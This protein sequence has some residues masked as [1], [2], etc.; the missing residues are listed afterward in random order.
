MRIALILTMTLL[1]G[2]L[3]AQYVRTSGSSAYVER[4]GFGVNARWL[5]SESFDDNCRVVNLPFAFRFFD[6]T[7]NTVNFSTNGRLSFSNAT[8]NVFDS[9]AITATAPVSMRD[10]IHAISADLYADY[11]ENVGIMAV[12]FEADRAVFQWRGVSLLTSSGYQRL[13]F[14]VHLLQNHTIELHFDQETSPFADPETFVSGLVNND[15]TQVVAGFGN[16][17]TQQTS[18]PFIDSEVIFTPMFTAANGL[19][20]HAR[21]PYVAPRVAGVQNNLVLQAFRVTPYGTG[22]T[23]TQIQ[24]GARSLTNVAATYDLAIDTAPLGQYNGET[25]LG[26]VAH[27]GTTVTIS[28]LSENIVGAPRDYIIFATITSIPNP[29]AEFLS[30]STTGVTAT[31]PVWGGHLGSI[32]AYTGGANASAIFSNGFTGLE[33]AA[34]GTSNAIIGSFEIRTSDAAFPPI[35]LNAL[36]FQFTHSG[37]VTDGAFSAVRLW[38]DYGKI[39][40]LD[41]VDQLLATDNALAAGLAAFGPFGPVSAD[42]HGVDFLITADITGGFVGTGSTSCALAAYSSQSANDD[43]IGIGSSLPRAILGT[44]AA[45]YIRWNITNYMNNWPVQPGDTGLVGVPFMAQTS[46]GAGSITALTFTNSGTGLLTGVTNARLLLDNGTTVGRVDAGDTPLTATIAPSGASFVCSAIAGLATGVAPTN[47]LFAFD[48]TAGA[49]GSYRF[50]LSAQTASPATVFKLPATLEGATYTVGTG[51]GMSGIDLT[52]GPIQSSSVTFGGTQFVLVCRVT[53]AARNMGGVLP[54]LEFDLTD[55]AGGIGTGAGLELR[56][57]AD[58]G[59]DTGILD[60]T[61]VHNAHR[62]SLANGTLARNSLPLN[63]GSMSF[64]V[65]V[66]LNRQAPHDGVGTLTLRGVSGGT[67]VQVIGGMGTFAAKKLDVR[68]GVVIVDG[69]ANDG[70]CSAAACDTRL[71]FALLG[72]VLSMML[73]AL[74]ARRS[75]RV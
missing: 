13:G 38:R 55:P 49:S 19:N 37:A 29:D 33:P 59:S 27:V 41:G 9:L 40:V 43:L 57:V 50:A 14:Q 63:S 26:S 4:A 75:R 31:S 1:A 45:T 2:G 5:L 25:P 3:C 74:R 70:G 35:N 58:V 16:V 62:F 60:L 30:L 12:F 42:E 18:F 36:D 20:L 69:G 28:T 24:F 64:L 53:A 6:R 11:R 23:I 15:G 67:N 72:G 8:A 32:I 44:G 68:N 46:T 73:V 39:G 10:C 47:V 21:D 71:D 52:I 51:A 54:A 22:G 7:Y 65:Y 56:I 17:L 34:A 61:D 48:L 66:Q